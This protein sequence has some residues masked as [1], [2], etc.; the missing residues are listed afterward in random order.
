MTFF[1]RTRRFYFFQFIRVS[2]LTAGLILL[3][4]AVLSSC[5]SSGGVKFAGQGCVGGIVVGG[6]AGAM[7]GGKEGAIIGAIGGCVAGLFTGLYFAERKAQYA[8]KQRAIIE[9]TAWN[10]N[11]AA[12]FRATNAELTK[13]IKQYKGEVKRINNMRMNKKQ[14]QMIKREEKK[15]FRQQFGG[16][17]ATAEQAKVEIKTSKTRYKQHKPTAQP[18]ELAKWQNGITAFEQQGN[19]LDQNVNHLLSMNNSL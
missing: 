17:I 16:A 15:K 8:S 10:K 12:K 3:L 5:V 1:Y 14:R 2:G 19:L 4:S 6:V 7:I 18:A 11:M 13:S 9:E